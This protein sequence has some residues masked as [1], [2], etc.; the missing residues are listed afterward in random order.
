MHLSF[1]V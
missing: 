1:T